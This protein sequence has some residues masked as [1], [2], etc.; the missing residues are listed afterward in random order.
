M[1]IDTAFSQFPILKTNRFILR[2]LRST[3]VDAIFAIF[4]NQEVMK[5]DGHLPMVTYDE[6]LAFIERMQARFEK[7]EAIRW[8]ITRH[9]DDTVIGTCS[10]HHFISEYRCVETGYDLN[11]AYWGQGIQIECMPAVLAFGFQDLGVE[12]IEAI[13]DDAN[14]ASKKLLLKLGFTYE[15]CLRHRYLIG[16]RMEDE[17][18]Y[19]LLKDEWLAARA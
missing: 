5:Y 3:D 14:T 2:Q 18:Y 11:R 1:S 6:A 13:I 16:D 7:R 17:F 19:R 15:G 8:A 4:S 12:R 9:D 10:F